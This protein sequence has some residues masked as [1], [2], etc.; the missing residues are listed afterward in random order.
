M[1]NKKVIDVVSDQ[2]TLWDMEENLTHGCGFTGAGGKDSQYYSVSFIPFGMRNYSSV[3][4][5]EDWDD[6]KGQS[7]CSFDDHFDALV[8]ANPKFVIK[9]IYIYRHGMEYL[10][11]S[12]TCRWD[13]GR[14]GCLAVRR[15]RGARLD[16][17]E[18]ALDKGF[19]LLNDY[20]FGPTYSFY[21]EEDDSWTGPL[22]S[23]EII[24]VAKEIYGEDK[25]IEIN[26]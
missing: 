26:Y 10:E 5:H 19:K 15:K 16:G 23:E 13:S 11:W 1:E 14:A 21:I 3:N 25:E 6:L 20:W 17:Y 4:K 9:E 7:F 24:S 22:T 2:C 8:R 18:S 12:P